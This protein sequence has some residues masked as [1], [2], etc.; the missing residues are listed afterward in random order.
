MRSALLLGCCLCLAS[1]RTGVGQP[2]TPAEEVG[3]FKLA[4]GFAAELV[5][6]ESEAA[7]NPYGKFVALAFDGRGRLW[8][9]T[10]LEYP[11]DGNENPEA[12]RRLFAAGG[13]DKVLVIDRP[14]G[15]RPGPARVFAD[16]LAIPLGVQPWRDGAFVQYGTEIRW[17]RDADGDGR[18]DGHQTV[19]EGFGV[20]DSHLFPHQFTR[21]PGGW[22]LVAQGLFNSST[23]KRPGGLPFADGSKQ[24][25]FDACKLARFKPDGSA[26]EL[27][28]AG[29]NNIW[30]LTISRLGQTWIQ[31]AN[32]MGYPIIPFEPGGLYR[33]GS[34]DR[35][36]PYQPLCPPPLAPPQM[37]GTGLSG[38]AIA[39]DLDG[40]PA[41]WGAGA[42]SSADER[43]FYVANPITNAIQSII[44]TRTGGRFTYRKGPDLLT[45]ADKC[46]RPVAIQFGP[47]GC[48]YVVDWYNKV[49]SHNE[50]PRNHPDRDRVRGR[51]WRIRHASQERRAPVAV[52]DLAVN[53]LPAHLG[54]KNARIADLAWQEIIDR[55]ARQLVPELRA[56]VADGKASPSARAGA[57]WALEGLGGVTPALLERLIEDTD[58]DLRRE[59]IRV[60]GST[61]SEAD[62]RRLAIS[63]VDDPV[64]RVRAAVGDALRRIPVTE[65]DTVA[66]I[67]KFG[68]ERL[69]GD[70]WA[71]YERNFE[72]Y[73][74]RWALE[75]HRGQL[76]AFLDSPAGRALP[77]EQR[78]FAVLALEPPAAARAL[79]RLLPDLPRPLAEEEIR[80]LAGQADQPEVAAALEGMVQARST[81]SAT[82]RTLLEFR[83]GLHP[84]FLPII[85][86]AT[87]ALLAQDGS[88][89]D[90]KLALL[91]AGAFRL[92]DLAP[93]VSML[94]GDAG[95]DRELKRSALRCLREMGGMSA[96]VG[97]TLLAA[98]ATDPALRAELLAAWCESRDPATCR[99]V[100]DAWDVLTF[101]ERKAVAAGLARHREGAS[102]VVAALASAAIEAGEVPLA[103]VAD[104]RSVLRGDETLERLW[105]DLT[106][107]APNVL[108]LSGADAGAAATV[109]LEGPFTV[110]AWVNLEAPIDNGDS[111]LGG[112]GRI[113]MNFHAGRLRIWTKPHGDVVVAKSTITPETWTHCAVTRDADGTCRIFLDGELDAEGAVRDSSRYPDLRIGTSVHPGSGTRGRMAEFRVWNRA[114]TADEI[115]SDFDR[116]YQGADERPAGLVAVHGGTSWGDLAGGARVEPAPDA[117]PLVTA[118]ALAARA[119]KFDRFRTLA[120]GAGDPAKGKLVFAARCLTCHQQGGQGGRIGP[121]LDGIGLTGV[122]AILRNVLTPSA[123]I[124]GGYRTFRVVTRDGRVLQGLLVSR[125]AEA[126]V[127]RQLDTADIRIESGNVNQADFTPVS[128]MPE[129]L[130]ESLS[131]QEVT[132]LFAHLATLVPERP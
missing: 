112:A 124:E 64:P 16:G 109:S 63:R 82:L 120:R 4:D 13:R 88:A 102:A 7:E 27:L 130:L 105:K 22:I 125:D 9:T 42:G 108:R 32:D 79:V 114:R 48:L 72:R 40:W 94:L 25:R 24:A 67:V 84:A 45:S 116:S 71:A 131:P 31:E 29:P 100:I 10:A 53:E 68:R 11:V 50:V 128:L 47:D 3:R 74:A 60:A 83:T 5:L 20:Q 115:R 57:L 99:A 39:D 28:T 78:A 75:L 76:T 86:R 18:A 69:T 8:T 34:P 107:G 81:R 33:T 93:Q 89:D 12:S 61:C 55:D 127:L 30:G 101:Q 54:A 38:L 80:A 110:E 41:P 66:M 1:G 44:A 104:M 58:A 49:I 90:R 35:L 51:I 111:L 77:I 85:S 117:P 43:V 129:G 15:E 14:F 59:G 113:D 118:A 56:M 119:E 19:L 52:A 95:A 121:A 62:F 26:F 97:R 36:Q 106:A 46:F 122:E 98:T 17:Y 103:T 65:P 87:G 6:A 73:L 21:V 126:I 91:L 2:L 123:A 132:D 37:G 96:E 23:V 92:R 70:P